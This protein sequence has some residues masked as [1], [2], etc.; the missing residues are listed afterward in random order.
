[1][2]FPVSVRRPGSMDF[3]L[4]CCAVVALV[5]LG[6]A[7]AQV[8]AKNPMVNE[9]GME[10]QQVVITAKLSRGIGML[11]V[12]APYSPMPIGTTP[13]EAVNSIS[14]Q[15]KAAPPTGNNTDK[16]CSI[17]GGTPAT[18][19]PVIIATGEKYQVEDDFASAGLYGL[20]HRRTYR[21]AS[22]YPAGMFGPGWLSTYSWPRLV[23]GS[24]VK[25][26]DFSCLRRTVTVRFPEGETFVYTYVPNTDPVQYTANGAAATG[27]M[28][29]TPGS[30][31]TLYKDGRAYAYSDAGYI[32]TIYD[33]GGLSMVTFAYNPAVS[34]QVLG[35]T[36]A[37]GKRISFTWGANGRVSSLTDP[38]G[39]VWAYGYNANNILV[40][41]SSPGPSPDIRQYLYESSVSPYLLTGI[42]VNGLRY[43]TYVYQG[44]G[45]V[46][47]SGLAGGE[48]KETFVYGTNQTQVTTA[49]GQVVTYGFANVLGS[50]KLVS[51]SRASTA[52]CGAAAASVSYDPNGYKS[53]ETDWNGNL[54][55]YTND[56]AGK[57]AQISFRPGTAEALT[58]MYWW[59]GQ[60]LTRVDHYDANMTLFQRVAYTYVTAT[61]GTGLLAGETFTDMRGSATRQVQYAYTFN[62]SGT[63][64]S[65]TR[66]VVGSAGNAVTT[67]T[68]DSFGNVATV[69]NALGQQ[70]S[71]SNYNGL[72]QPGSF[73]D[74]NGVQTVY[75][76]APNGNLL[77]ETQYLPTGPRT[78]SYAYDNS[79]RMTDVVFPDGRASRYRYNAAGRVTLVGNAAQE[80][81]QM[82]LD[83]ASNTRT[84]VSARHVPSMSGQSPV[85]VAAGPFVTT[86]RLDSL[87]RPWID[88]GNSGQQVTY[89]YDA[90]GNLTSRVDAAGRRTGYSYDGMNR[91]SAIAAADGGVTT[92]RYNTEGR[93]QSVRDPRGLT[94]QYTYDGLG[95][96]LTT[97]SP[98]SGLTSVAYDAMGRVVQETRANGRRITYSWDLMGRLVARVSGSTTESFAYDEG[99]WGKGKMTRFTDVTGQTTYAYDA[100]GQLI[101]QTSSIVGASYALA[102]SYDSAGRLST[103]SYPGGL[104]L[105]YTYDAF[106]RLARIASNLSGA[107]ATILSSPLYQPATDRLYAWRWGNGLSRLVTLDS[108]SRVAALS[109]PGVHGLSFGFTSTNTIGTVADGVYPNLSASLSYDAVDRLT[110]VQRSGDNQTFAWDAV[111][112]RTGQ[113]R[114]GASS[115]YATNP[116]GNHL[117]TMTGSNPRTFGY[118]ASG[119]LASDARSDGTRTFGYDNFDRL[120]SVYLNGRLIGDYRSNALGQRVYKN[121]ANGW[122][123][124]VYAADGTLMYEDGSQ[125][126]A[127]VWVAGQLIGFVRSGVFY[128]SHNDQLGRPEVIANG[129]GAV[130]WRAENAAFDRRIVTD[131]IGG[132]NIGFPGQYLDGETG[133]AYNWNRYYDASSGRYIQSDPIGLAGGINTY[134]YA[135]GN[136]ISNFDLTG[137]DLCTIDL[138]GLPGAQLDDAFA[139]KVSDWISRNQAD[140]I[141]VTFTEAFRSSAYQA[142][143]AKSP[144]AIGPAK[145]GDSWHEAGFAVDISWRSLTS[146]QRSSVVANAK[147]AG[148]FWGGDFRMPDPVHFQF[149]AGGKVKKIAAAQA[150]ANGEAKCGC[151]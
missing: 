81:V 20:S 80:F 45:R 16:P 118:D 26:P 69:T 84:V 77:S 83:V 54:T 95:E 22:G 58:D 149:D 119:N 109:S 2:T 14:A 1:M 11:G 60:N 143:L 127:Y 62:P 40:S 33:A 146:D 31:W 29:Y 17:D 3:L 70:S 57:Y 52:S 103:L 93:L 44:D 49:T 111:G 53:G 68:F 133:L 35:V 98:D 142:S 88:S 122:T 144:N 129:A 6:S 85:G 139:S 46:S 141:S 121:T 61:P 112:N 101:G 65:M 151:K 110:A 9:G 91:L 47:V 36:N 79:R 126:T 86:R 63:M 147:A 12:G 100:A 90:N 48:E 130:V 43:S 51:T 128:S 124:F 71:W 10:T 135:S 32:Q 102:W 136:P 115:S 55:V 67:T 134:A 125:P 25:T 5:G 27:S 150:K 56:P 19:H 97:S 41:A 148:L 92:M 120:A 74:A 114:A 21:S 140:G 82:N 107:S 123:R 23:F 132:L 66:T 96:P 39:N 30:D 108:D 24:C 4:T 105:S 64:A 18:G 145:V 37:V 104:I 89:G 116:Q 34:G 78:T 50:L 131:G 13:R 42:V 38:S 59:E 113:V 138:P 99:T 73:T 137:L 87:N 72:G 106:G 7:Q 28:V 117:F 15:S 8:T 94:T 76:Y 75:A